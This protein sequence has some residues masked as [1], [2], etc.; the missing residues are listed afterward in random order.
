M[1]NLSFFVIMA[2]IF[3]LYACGSDPSQSNFKI[4][5]TDDTPSSKASVENSVAT[6]PV[7]FTDGSTIFTVTEAR[8]NIRNIEFDT[9]ADS[10]NP[11]TT[12]AI[13]G[14]FVMNLLTGAAE[15][16]SI[17]FTPPA[18]TYNRVD[19]RLDDADLSDGVLADGDELLNNTL[20][21]KG[22]HDYGAGGNFSIILKFNEDVRFEPAA[23]ITISE[24]GGAS[25]ELALNVSDWLVVDPVGAPN[26]A[27]D[28][29]SCFGTDITLTG[30]DFV[31]DD[32]AGTTC[33]STD[34]ENLIKT[35]MKNMYD[36]SS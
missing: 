22:T 25:V 29:T 7:T 16:S 18:G 15:P 35:N 8:A 13:N 4:V 3:T 26:V 24:D 36:F 21:I 34:V 11:G 23:G 27:L 17:I 5:V 31:L 30:N 19:V 2:V 10:A 14:P 32:T 33:N 1:K 9:S 28:L 6:G 12:H 20:V